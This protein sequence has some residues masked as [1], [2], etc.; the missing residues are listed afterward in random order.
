M[1][2][3]LVFRRTGRGV[4]DNVKS[5]KKEEIVAALHEKLGRTQ[6]VV[7]TNYKGLNV[8]TL[9]ALRRKLNAVGVE[10]K[11]VKNTLLIRASQETAV[12]QIAS[13]FSGPSA[14][15][16]SYGD[17]VTPAKILS[18][19][20]AENEKFSIKS[21]VMGGKVLTP[22]GL[23]AL[24]ALPAREVLLAQV[25]GTLNSVPGSLVRALADVPRRMLNVL[26]AVRDQRAA[27]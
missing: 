6:M 17:P 26:T 10:Y 24:S 2:P 19:F 18:E 12:A 4:F 1:L 8:A 20:A 23:K 21:G 25:L 7:L 9:S 16:L 13:E 15:A 22:E 14:V 11:V 5:D 3:P 27:A